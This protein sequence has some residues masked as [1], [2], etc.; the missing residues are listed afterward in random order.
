[1]YYEGESLTVSGTFDLDTDKFVT[2][3][4]LLGS[5]AGGTAGAVDYAGEIRAALYRQAAGGGDYELMAAA[6]ARRRKRRSTAGA[7]RRRQ[8]TTQSWGNG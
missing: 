8:A 5:T 2:R 6:D 7:L 3:D 4:E 1:M